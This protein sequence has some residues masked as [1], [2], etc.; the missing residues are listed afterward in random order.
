MMSGQQKQAVISSMGAL[1]TLIVNEVISEACLMAIVTRV[2]RLKGVPLNHPPVFAPDFPEELV[3][4][5]GG[6][7]DLAPFVTDP[8]GDTLAFTLTDP[9][10][11]AHISPE[12]VLTVDA[13]GEGEVIVEVDD[14]KP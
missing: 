8:D 5:V 12:G 1:T 10:G 13:E 2:F 6:T 11:L 4:P 14:G 9:Q 7:V 3:V